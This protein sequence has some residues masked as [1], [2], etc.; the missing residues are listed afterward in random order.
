MSYSLQE[1]LSKKQRVTKVF[2]RRMK[3]LDTALKCSNIVAANKHRYWGCREGYVA[4]R[5]V[6]KSIFLPC[7]PNYG[8]SLKYPSSPLR[9]SAQKMYQYTYPRGEQPPEGMPTSLRPFRRYLWGWGDA[10]QLKGAG[11]HKR[12]SRKES[13]RFFLLTP[14]SGGRAIS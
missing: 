7:V 10:E 5:I 3:R 6:G 12:I 1:Q 13:R 4:V 2:W 11:N 14:T 8:V 9:G